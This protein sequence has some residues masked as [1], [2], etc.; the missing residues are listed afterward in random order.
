[1]SLLGSLLLWFLL[2]TSLLI[3]IY[4]PWQISR[5]AG[6][7]FLNNNLSIAGLAPALHI[8]R[9]APERQKRQV[10]WIS[11]E[12]FKVLVQRRPRDL[13]VIDLRADAPWS[14]FPVADVFVLAVTPNELTEALEWLPSD[15]SAVFYGISNLSIARVQTSPSM[16]GSAPF[17]FLADDFGSLEVA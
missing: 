4:P 3:L 1:M 14:P 7:H 8:V 10:N 15:R 5:A 6:R 9:K 17:Y 16:D 12:E 2:A 13:I 11:F